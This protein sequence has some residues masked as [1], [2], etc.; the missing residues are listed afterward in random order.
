MEKLKSGIELNGYTLI[1]QIGIGA[2]AEVWSAKSGHDD[3]ELALK[4]FAPKTHLDDYSKVLIKKEYQNA[5]H[6]EHENIVTPIDYF[7]VEQ[8]PVLVMQKYGPSL[9]NI[10]KERQS[11]HLRQNID[12]YEDLFSEKELAEILFDVSKALTYLH[13]KGLIHNDIKP[14]NI[15]TQ[16][17]QNRLS[18]VLSDFGIT[19]EIRETILRQ[20]SRNYQSALTMAYAS[21]ER[22]RGEIS[23]TTKGDMFSLGCS[24][25]EL[26]NADDF[27]FG[28]G[29]I[30]NNNG[31]IA[32]IRGNYSSAYN[33]VITELLNINPRNRL[34]ANDLREICYAYLSTNKWPEYLYATVRNVPPA[35]RRE[36]HTIKNSDISAR[37]GSSKKKR[38]MIPVLS[39]SV[40]LFGLYLFFGSDFKLNDKN[41]TQEWTS[42]PIPVGDYYFAQTYDNRCVLLDDE[43]KEVYPE[44]IFTNCRETPDAIILVEASGDS[45]IVNKTRSHGR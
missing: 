41:S 37:T 8:N 22:L 38:I 14:A 12:H 2:T 26:T 35:E 34:A 31:A 3:T 19:R 24:M 10:L 32:P 45:I 9:W 4:I 36:F 27:D 15:L 28:P 18:Y 39:L 43:K 30:L 13:Y 23:N 6:L 20:T 7:E 21:P 25:Y 40:I 42:S 1:T 5:A 29:S 16:Q 11:R 44:K 33:N 17:D